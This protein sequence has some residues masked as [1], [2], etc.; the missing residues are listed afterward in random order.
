MINPLDRPDVRRILADLRGLRDG[1]D[2]VS[3]DEMTTVFYVRAFNEYD[4]CVRALLE[5]IDGPAPEKIAFL[6]EHSGDAARAAL[7]DFDP[8]IT[9][10]ERR[11]ARATSNQSAIKSGL[12]L[13]EAA[14]ALALSRSGVRHRIKAGRLY[15]FNLARRWYLPRW[16]FQPGSATGR[17]EPIPGLETVVPAIPDSMHPL[18]IHIFMTTPLMELREHAPA[19]YLRFGGSAEAV[20][21][22]LTSMAH[23]Y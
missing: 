11:R 4:V 20:A 17:L 13:G 19:S 12:T 14:A 5:A 2:A 23:E 3:L 1:F 22:W 15:A 7:D 16:Q 10:E 9:A 18:A 8:A 6:R 21:S